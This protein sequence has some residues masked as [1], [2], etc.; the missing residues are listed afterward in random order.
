MTR[1]MKVVILG[2]IDS[3]PNYQD[4]FRRAERVITSKV[5]CVVLTSTVL[6]LRVI[7]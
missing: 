3:D 6:P 7:P 1:K 4:K 5:D 2:A